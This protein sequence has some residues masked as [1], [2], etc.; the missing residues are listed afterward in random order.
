MDRRTRAEAGLVFRQSLHNNN[1]AESQSDDGSEDDFR[2]NLSRAISQ[3]NMATLLGQGRKRKGSR[4]PEKRKVKV[5]FYYLPDACR[6]PKFTV[7]PPEDLIEIHMSQ[8][9]G[10]RFILT[11][12]IDGRKLLTMQTA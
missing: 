2:L 3:A 1:N 8:G 5:K 6:V 9:F 7:Q 4:G 11:T 12:Y 10:K